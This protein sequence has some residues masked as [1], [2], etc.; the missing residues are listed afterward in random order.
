M[1]GSVIQSHLESIVI[2]SPQ[3]SSSV[4]KSPEV[5]SRVLKSVLKSYNLSKLERVMRMDKHF[6]LFKF[7]CKGIPYFS[8]TADGP[9]C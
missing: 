1:R 2:Q 4:L 6:P 9:L 5:S 3:E 8:L 7:F